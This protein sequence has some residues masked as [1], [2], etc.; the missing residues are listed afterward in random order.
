MAAAIWIYSA[1]TLIRSGDAW[2]GSTYLLILLMPLLT[3]L[4]LWCRN[5]RKSDQNVGFV[6]KW[7][8]LIF[9]LQGVALGCWAYDLAT[10]FY[11]ID[12]ARAAVEINPLGWPLGALGAMSYYVPTILLSYVLLFRF[13]QKVSL[14]AAIPIT[15]VALLM[16]S[17][18][19][20][21]GIENFKFFAVSA[22]LPT[23][24]RSSL[25][26]LVAAVDL[27]YVAVLAK[28]L[29]KWFP[30]ITKGFGASKKR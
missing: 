28:T 15:A 9:S 25:L 22:W 1:A 29:T 30:A 13:K 19:L 12:I 2:L 24:I 10:T 20:N 11:A 7:G 6:G 17:M 23:N 16:G 14:Y 4:Y 27:A 26:A 5:K 21:A 3:G 8:S 18:N